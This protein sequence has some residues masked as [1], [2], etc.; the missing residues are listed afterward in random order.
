MYNG[1]IYIYVYF[2]H[3][4]VDLDLMD[5]HVHTHIYIYMYCVACTRV[6]IHV[7]TYTRYIEFESIYI[8]IYASILRPG[9]VC[10]ASSGCLQVLA[11]SLGTGL[12]PEDECQARCHEDGQC[13]SASTSHKA[14]IGP[15]TMM[16]QPF[17]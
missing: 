2:S 8:Y 3:P 15:W 5:T 7:Y 9:T 12:S 1:H 4:F 14:H 6:I 10:R 11:S 16:P 17:F 13:I